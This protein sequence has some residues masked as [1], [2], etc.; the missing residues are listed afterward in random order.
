MAEELSMQLS[1]GDIAVGTAE[2]GVAVAVTAAGE[3]QRRLW[4]DIINLTYEG[5]REISSSKMALAAGDRGRQRRRNDNNNKGLSLRVR[6]DTSRSALNQGDRQ[7]HQQASNMDDDAGECIPYSVQDQCDT[8]RPM[9]LQPSS[10]RSTST[11]GSRTDRL[12]HIEVTEQ[13]VTAK[14]LAD[15][16]RQGMEVPRPCASEENDKSQICPLGALFWSLTIRK[17]KLSCLLPVA[18]LLHGNSGICEINIDEC[19]GL[20]LKGIECV[21]TEAPCLRVLAIRRCGLT[22]LPQLRSESVEELDIS[23]NKI[24]NAAGLE[25][26]F[27]LKKLNMAENYVHTLIDLRPL[28]PLG[29]GCI[30]ELNLEGNP[31]QNI[32]RYDALIMEEWA[33]AVYQ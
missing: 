30:R 1:P 33:D 13:E 20:T 23:R 32:P 11:M 10:H 6:V 26:L 25:T 21:L 14:S 5:E 15:A 2:D 29:M 3:E 28:I 18:G 19:A 12:Q 4:K 22:R 9:C 8:G 7:R 17:C 27:R 31:V 16:V 24:E